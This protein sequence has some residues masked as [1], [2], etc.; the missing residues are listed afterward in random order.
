MIAGVA[1]ATPTVAQIREALE[2]TATDLGDTGWDQYFGHG[3]VN[4]DAALAHLR[5]V[6]GGGTCGIADF[7]GDGDSG[8]DADI[9]AFF[10]CLGGSCCPTCFSG[11][12]D[13]NGD[14]DAGTDADIEAFFRVLA[15]GTC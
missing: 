4:A 15:G 8:T 12:S 5:G 14:G 11:G 13:F 1:P 3:L 7:N 6:L 10:Q 9:E 2:Q